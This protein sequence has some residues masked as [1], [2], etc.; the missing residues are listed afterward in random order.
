MGVKIFI[1]TRSFQSSVLFSK[2][3]VSAV[4]VVISVSFP[5]ILLK[6]VEE[7]AH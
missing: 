2:S 1:E 5:S 6:S 4:S 3:K 7:V